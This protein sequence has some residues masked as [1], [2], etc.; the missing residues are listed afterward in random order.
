[1]S[2]G[3]VK[4]GDQ[5]EVPMVPPRAFL[6][7]GAVNYVTPQ[8]YASLLKE[9]EAIIAERESA[10]GNETDLR[11]TRNYLNFK[12]ELL[13][14]RI[15]TAVVVEAPSP[16]DGTIGLGACVTF[17]T[18]VP[19]MHNKNPH[20]PK[21]IT[22]RITG[23]DESDGTKN[24]SF[25]SPLAMALSGHK[26]GEELKIDLPTGTQRIKVLSV[27]Y[28]VADSS[29]MAGGAS[30]PTALVREQRSSKS[31]TTQPVASPITVPTSVSTAAPASVPLSASISA[32]PS[33]SDSAPSR[34]HDPQL[35]TENLNEI[36]PIVN[37]RGHTIG[38]AARWQCHDGSKLLHP[39]VH[40][41]LFNSK[42]ELYLQKRPVW[43]DIQPGKWDTSVG[44]HMA[45]GE[46][47]EDA[48]KR[49][50]MEEL[51]IEGFTPIFVK[52]YVFE[53]TREKELV[54]VYKTVYDG[55]I[56]PS[57]E[58]DGGRFWSIDEIK[59]SMGKKILTPN[60]E[61]EYRRVFGQ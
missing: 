57:E 33:T 40:L 8:G 21:P 9:K 51:G 58:L 61:G 5:E 48:L 45:F 36:F 18:D 14:E 53:S 47:P 20:S 42:G 55:V 22:I 49:E 44:G 7:Q 17:Q 59:S 1:M 37:D 28:N 12:L 30:E 19:N 10:T 11:V 52:R 2:R 32:A 6:P 26:A 4:E 43:K 23:A 50:A 29:V 39:V 46:K 41:H 24:L 13:D 31:T 27:T 35:A 15:R 34:T 56:C 60:F 25:F 3:F 54:Y 38:R 16:N